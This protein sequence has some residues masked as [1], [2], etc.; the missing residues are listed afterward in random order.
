MV[1][2]GLGSFGGEIFLGFVEGDSARLH[3]Q[4]LFFRFTYYLRTM[5][6]C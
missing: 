1:R 4:E 5:K 2:I 6:S 3:L